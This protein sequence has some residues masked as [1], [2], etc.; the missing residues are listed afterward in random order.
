[1]VA[2]GTTMAV[3]ARRIANER[4]RANRE[5]EAS[6]RVSEFMANMF[7]VFDP[8]EAR[9]NSVTAREILDRA[10]HEIDPG[11]AKD[12]AL[13]A[14]MMHLMGTVYRNLGLFPRAESL[15]REASETQQIAL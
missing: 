12:P 11:L 14:R 9:G 2:F 4:D 10:S 5:A 7:K 6:K 1:L 15:L 3:Q 13:R 8:S